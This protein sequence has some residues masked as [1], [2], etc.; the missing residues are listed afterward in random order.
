MAPD[1]NPSNTSDVVGEFARASKSD[2]MLPSRPRA[3]RFGVVKTTPQ[4]RFDV[5]DK[6]GRKSWR[7]RT[8][9]ASS[10]RASRAS[11]SPTA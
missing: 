11:P 5:L 10:S 3:R 9:W 8:S 6:A 7:A 2:W 4:A 1:I